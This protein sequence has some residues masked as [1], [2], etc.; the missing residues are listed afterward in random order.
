MDG[1][2]KNRERKNGILDLV[3]FALPIVGVL[4]VLLSNDRPRA[5]KM[6]AIIGTAVGLIAAVIYNIF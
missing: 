3:F 6:T 5:M 1:N 2:K 4:V